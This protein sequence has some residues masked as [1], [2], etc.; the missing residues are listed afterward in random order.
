MGGVRFSG[1]NYRIEA[2]MD[3]RYTDTVRLLL[4]V[5]PDVFANDIFAIKGGT[6]I[7]GMTEVDCSLETLLEARARLRRELPQWLTTKA[8]AVSERSGP[9]RTRLVFVA[10]P[11]CGRTASAALETQQP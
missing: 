5:A 2:I 3:K 10:M 1:G 6:A 9:C 4:A 11:T 8:P 7:S